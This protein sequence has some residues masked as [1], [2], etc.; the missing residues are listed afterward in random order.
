VD[1]AFASGWHPNDFV[2]APDTY[3]SR[4]D[5]MYAG[6]RQVQRYWRGETSSAVNG[7]GEKVDV[8]IYPTPIQA[9]LP[10]WLTAASSPQTFTRAGELGFNMITHL[11]DQR[12]DELA[13]NIALYRRARVDSGRAA[14]GGTVTVT[15][16]TFIG[17][18]LEQV[19]EHTRVPYRK[20]LQSNLG[21]LKNLAISRGMD[22][23][24]DSQIEQMIDY[25]FEKFVGGRSLLGTPDSCMQMARQL[26]E[27]GVDEIACL[28]DFG[29]A[30]PR[31]LE[32]LP[33]LA[34]LANSMRAS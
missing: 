8:R 7:K 32:N 25:M 21:L 17:E 10:I 12:V 29:P 14:D 34:T 3:E 26:A 30:T 9:N 28:V 20:Y 11:F 15:L 5:C 13:K 2:L 22:R 33:H 1:V 24:G 23:L 6:I 18:T 16:H 31:I 19:R 4:Y 27:M